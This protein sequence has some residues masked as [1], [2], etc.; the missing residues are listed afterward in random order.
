MVELFKGIK[1][2]S[3]RIEKQKSQLKR[4]I[5]M[6]EGPKPKIRSERQFSSWGVLLHL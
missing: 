5:G 2:V 6:K 3:E 4:A 1:K